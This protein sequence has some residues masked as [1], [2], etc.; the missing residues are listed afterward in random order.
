MVDSTLRPRLRLRDV[1]RTAQENILRVFPL[2]E[3]D[4]SRTAE[5]HVAPVWNRTPEALQES[6]RAGGPVGPTC[7]YSEDIVRRKAF[8]QSGGREVVVHRDEHSRALDFLPQHLALPQQNVEHVSGSSAE[9]AVHVGSKFRVAFHA[10]ID[11]VD[12]AVPLDVARR[13]LLHT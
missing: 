6:L 2:D 12:Q 8:E 5:V 4:F 11:A 9:R 1:D 13:K 10:S 3:R 7:P